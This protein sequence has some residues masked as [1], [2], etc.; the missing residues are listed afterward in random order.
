MLSWDLE[1][2]VDNILAKNHSRK[3]S[4]NPWEFE[5]PSGQVVN[6]MWRFDGMGDLMLQGFDAGDKAIV[7]G[8]TLF[9]GA[10]GQ[11]NF[12]GIAWIGGPRFRATI[13]LK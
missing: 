2:E 6:Q 10:S 13:D 4:R 12:H 5:D 7:G 1:G 11:I 8:T 9:N 3:R